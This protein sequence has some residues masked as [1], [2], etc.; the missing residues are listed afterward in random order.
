MKTFPENSWNVRMLYELNWWKGL[1]M[2]PNAMHSIDKNAEFT[3]SFKLF[4]LHNTHI[5]TDD[6]AHTTHTCILSPVSPCRSSLPDHKWPQGSKY[7]SWLNNLS[8]AWSDSNSDSIPCPHLSSDVGH[9]LQSAEA[10]SKK[11]P[12]AFALS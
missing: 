9:I 7:T 2:C 1:S 4:Y 6:W 5:C 8:T 12:V 10:E 3:Y 11:V